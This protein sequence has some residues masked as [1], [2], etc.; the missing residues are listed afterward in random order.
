MSTNKTRIA[1]S[2]FSTAGIPFQFEIV[3][4][5]DIYQESIDYV[6]TWLQDM[7]SQVGNIYI[8]VNIYS[9]NNDSIRYEANGTTITKADITYP[10][11]I[12]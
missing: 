12:S 1:I 8:L 2:D 7:I 6:E 10:N 5:F 4:E 3:L 9:Y 11:L